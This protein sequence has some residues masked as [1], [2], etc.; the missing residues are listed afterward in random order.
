MPKG[1][2][3]LKDSDVEKH[4]FIKRDEDDSFVF[5]RRILGSVSY[6]IDYCKTFHS[7]AI[8]RRSLP[9]FDVEVQKLLLYDKIDIDLILRRIWHYQL[10]ISNYSSS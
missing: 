4:G 5:Y 2:Y 6:D 1:N 3:D 9:E 7:V 10:D 8:Y